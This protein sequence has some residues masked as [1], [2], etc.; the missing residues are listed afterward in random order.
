[1]SVK[2][3]YNEK[4]FLDEIEKY[5][6]STYNGHYVEENEV[7]FMD[8][9]MADKKDGIGFLKHNISK[10]VLRYGKKEGYNRKDL[11]KSVHYILLLLHKT[12][13][14]ERRKGKHETK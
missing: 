11:F 1:M 3:K 10:Y 4:K 9:I 2:F 13:L 5:I 8:L 7:Q 12:D 6:E 14:E